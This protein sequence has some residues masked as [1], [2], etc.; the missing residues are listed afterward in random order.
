[1]VAEAAAGM[2]FT[3]RARERVPTAKGTL[4]ML[5]EFKDF[6]NKGNVVP[7]AVGLVMALYFQKIVDAVL[8]GVINPLIAAILGEDN[9]TSIGFNI[10]DPPEPGLGAGGGDKDVSIGLLIDAVISFL[11]VALFLFLVVKLYNHWKRD[12]PVA[13][14]TDTSCSRRSATCSPRIGSA[15]RNHR[16]PT[17]RAAVAGPRRPCS[18]SGCPAAPSS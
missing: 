1:M 14:S 13:A 3:D 17:W 9:F 2:C 7:I 8:N 10:G 4:P 6:I 16:R 15:S 5:K 18:M 12:D 11:A